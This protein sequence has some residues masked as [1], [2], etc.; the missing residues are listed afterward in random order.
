MTSQAQLAAKAGVAVG[1]VQRL[2]GERPYPQ[3]PRRA[4]AVE[5][6]LGWSAGTV[7]G[8]LDGEIREMPG[9]IP[10]TLGSEVDSQAYRAAVEQ[11]RHLSRREQRRL[12]ADLGLDDPEN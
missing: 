10:T 9:S 3:L 6:A 11:A 1:T 5:R 2:E 7:R 12:F 8:I 4:P